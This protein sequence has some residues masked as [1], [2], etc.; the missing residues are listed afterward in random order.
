[1]EFRASEQNETVIGEREHKQT[2]SQFLF[3]FLDKWNRIKEIR[4]EIE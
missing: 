3:C 4:T 1:M 2:M